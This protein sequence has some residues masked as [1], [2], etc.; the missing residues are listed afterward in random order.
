MTV[1][2]YQDD[3]VTL[4]HGD[5]LKIT[6]WLAADV[7]V[8][9]PPYG[10]EG[11]AGYG[12]AGG[13][14]RARGESFYIAND[15]TT[16]VR[17]KALAL[18]GDRPRLVFASPRLPEPPG[19]WND[20]LVWDKREP[21]LNG[22]PW[23]Y[24][25]ELIFV[26]GKGWVRQSASSFSVL[27]HPSGN[28]SYE[29]SLHAHAKPVPLMESLLGS[30]PEG[31]IADPFFGS[32]GTVI[33]ARNMGRKIIACELSLKHCESTVKRLSQQTF[34]MFP[35]TDEVRSSGWSGTEQT[36]DFGGEL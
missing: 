29:K 24:T 21:G 32:G 6:E 7:L 20:R 2:Y 28:G 25:H 4:Y 31:V 36:F 15:Q 18:W 27:S 30:A 9:D 12:R 22:G 8:T 3:L 33:A 23:R 26:G 10:S 19:E 14:G 1:P 35:V 34:R 11:K 17:D 13:N 16:E 5:C